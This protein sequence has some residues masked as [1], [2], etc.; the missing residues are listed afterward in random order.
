MCHVNPSV[1]KYQ[2]ALNEP[3]LM[4]LSMWKKMVVSFKTKESVEA[5]V[6]VGGGA[7]VIFNLCCVFKCSESDNASKGPIN[8]RADKEA[9]KHHRPVRKTK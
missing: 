7:M 1:S 8:C 9:R 4:R 3:Y 6:N 5:N 2:N